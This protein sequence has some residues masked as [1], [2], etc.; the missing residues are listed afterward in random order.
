MK[1]LIITFITMLL[2]SISVHAEDIN[3][4]FTINNKYTIFSMLAINSILQNNKSDS[5]YNFYILENDLTNKNK[6]KMTKYVKQRNQDIYFMNVNPNSILKQDAIY[7]VINGYMPSII[8]VRIMIAD[9]L[10]KDVHKVLYL[11][12]DTCANEDLKNL[13][14]INIEN[15]FAGM[16]RDW[17]DKEMAEMHK[18]DKYYN[19]GV[20]LM[21]LDM[22]RKENI[23]QKI[24]S[25]IKN[26]EDKFCQSGEENNSFPFPDQDLINI[27]LNEKIKEIPQKWNY[28]VI[29]INGDTIDNANKTEGI[30]HFIG[31]VKPWHFPVKPCK[32]LKIYYKYW[33]SSKLKKYK[34][35][36]EFLSIKKRLIN[37]YRRI[38]EKFIK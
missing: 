24:L 34:Y 32:Y 33:N 1:K 3:V 11:D 19:S 36:Y 22:W 10:P 4:V 21:N 28:Q 8:M 26:N 5:H 16:A 15:Y 14:D 12:G 29:S 35:Y 30:F 2:M 38:T 27:I 7:S 18:L 25:F 9:I 17:S 31:P 6:E 23:S 37:K 13:F 20:I